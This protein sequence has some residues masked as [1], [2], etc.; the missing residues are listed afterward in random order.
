M[1]NRLDDEDVQTLVFDLMGTCTDWKSTITSAMESCEALR[2]SLSRA[3]RKDLAKAWRARF[4]DDIH[5]R[6]SKGLPGEHIDVTH[7]RILDKMLEELGLSEQVI[8]EADRQ[9]LVQSWHDQLGMRLLLQIS[10]L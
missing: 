6:F 5:D 10:L 3:Q 9:G 8:R 7:R 4:F 2:S 1:T